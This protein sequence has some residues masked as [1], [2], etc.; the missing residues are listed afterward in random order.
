MLNSDPTAGRQAIFL[1]ATEPRAA[2]P[3]RRLAAR[4]IAL[5]ISSVIF[6]LASVFAPQSTHGLGDAVRK[7]LPVVE[8]AVPDPIA[9]AGLPGLILA[10]GGLLG[11][12]RRGQRTGAFS[13]RRLLIW[14][15]VAGFVPRSGCPILA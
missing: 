15:Q 11:W 13:P 1:G 5:S 4:V 10:S 2:R 12:W 14:K 9:S 7:F 8:R 3:E 6:R